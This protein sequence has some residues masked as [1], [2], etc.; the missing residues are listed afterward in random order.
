M[1]ATLSVLCRAKGAIAKRVKGHERKSE[2]EGMCEWCMCEKQGK[3]EV[4]E[5]QHESEQDG[6]GEGRERMHEVG[7]E[8]GKEGRQV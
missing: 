1:L 5:G 6:E 7:R 2:R 8:K 4:G 3:Q